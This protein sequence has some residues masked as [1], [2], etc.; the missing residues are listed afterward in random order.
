VIHLD[1]GWFETDWRSD[2]EF[3]TT[4][5]ED[6]ATMIADLK[7]EGFH[8]SLW[9]LP[10]FVPQNRLFP[11]IVE[12]GLAVLDPRGNIPYED[13]VLDFTNPATVDWYQEKIAN[14]LRLGVGAIKVDF[15]EAAPMNGQ[16]ASGRT[17]W[18]EHNLYPLLYN[19]A[20]AE[21]TREITGENIIWARSTWAGSQRYPLHWGGDAANSDTGM[22][23]TLRGGLSLGLSGFSFWSHDIGGFTTK[24]PE[25]LYRRWL[26][27]GMLTSHTRSHGAPPKEP[28]EY[29]P[30]FTDAFRRA[31]ELRYRLMPYIY[32][33]ARDSSERGLPMLRALF[34]EYPQDPGSWLV[35]D[36]YLFGRDM[37]VAPLMEEGA[38]GRDVYLPPGEWVDYQTG[39][40]YS[41]GWQA[42]EAGEIPVVVLVRSGAVVPHIALAQSTATMDWSEIEL[43][44]FGSEVPEARGLI[45]LPSDNVLH[46]VVLKKEGGSL[47]LGENPL[48]GQTTLAIRVVTA[49]S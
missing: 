27:F 47:V 28:W 34:I 46:E 32:A 5:F 1:T 3:S 39:R 10:Y 26:P 44:S 30:D 49:G 41:G 42:I 19:R 2:F 8:I 12:K 24:T 14:L 20:V 38:T 37:L 21:I 36:E 25:E 7:D 35:E 31:D 17:G 43:V 4:R 33:Q 16:Y 22:A 29:G 48:V 6:P 13:A 9:Q 15:G 11:E 18:Y 45:C 23:G 40:N